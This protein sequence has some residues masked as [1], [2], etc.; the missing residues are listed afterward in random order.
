MR[1]YEVV[2]CLVQVHD[3]GMDRQVLA[4]VHPLP[5]EPCEACSCG[6]V[7]ALDICRVYTTVIVCTE[8]FENLLLVPEHH[9]LYYIHH[10]P[11]LSPFAYLGVLE[12]AMWHP[13]RIVRSPPTLVWWTF[14][15]T[16]YLDQ[17]D[18]ERIPVVRREHGDRAVQCPLALDIPVQRLG[19]LDGSSSLVV[20]QKYPCIRLDRDKAVL[21]SYALLARLY[22]FLLFLM[23]VQISSTCTCVSSISAR[24]MS[25][26]SLVC[27]PATSIQSMMVFGLCPV[28]R[29]AA[30]MLPRSGIN[31][32]VRITSSIGVFR[33]KNGVPCVS[34]KQWPQDLQSINA[35][36]LGPFR[37]FRRMFPRPL[38]P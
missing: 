27:C 24:N 21:I 25:L 8:Y 11:V 34:L 2:P 16:E 23:N 3:P 6:Q 30:R 18:L 33:P 37:S 26:T 20:A 5:H 38:S 28:Y 1:F 31:A 13:H 14:Q 22:V 10:S 17:S 4:E 15:R 36:W 9:T 32:R 19:I 7:E 12:I 29:A 35:R